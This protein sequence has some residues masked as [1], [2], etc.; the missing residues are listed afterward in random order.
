MTIPLILLTEK[1][2]DQIRGVLNCFDR[3][4][5]RIIGVSCQR[6]MPR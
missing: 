1:Y 3:L 4:V 5:L 6:S 2:R